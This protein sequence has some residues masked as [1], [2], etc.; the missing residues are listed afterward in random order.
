MDRI[1]HRVENGAESALLRFLGGA[2]ERSKVAVRDGNNTGRA[3]VSSAMARLL[4]VR[5]SR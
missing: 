4:S 3:P 1:E 5:L 2:K